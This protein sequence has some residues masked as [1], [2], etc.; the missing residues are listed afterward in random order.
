MFLEGFQWQGIST[1]LEVFS[2]NISRYLEVFQRISTYLEVIREYIKIFGRFAENNNIFG[3]FSRNN[4]I[5]GSFS[6]NINI[7]GSF[8]RNIN[9]FGKDI[10]H[11]CSCRSVPWDLKLLETGEKKNLDFKR[12]QVQIK[13][14]WNRWKR[15]KIGFQRKSV[16][17]SKNTWNKFWQEK[18]RISSSVWKWDV[19]DVPVSV[20]M[21]CKSFPERDYKMNKHIS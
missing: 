9:I 13:I 5:F 16:S 8:S 1:Y 6:R 20:N 18:K 17:S 7:F 11:S 2:G 21:R 14:I 3:S 4:N 15:E 19:C 10:M 12:N